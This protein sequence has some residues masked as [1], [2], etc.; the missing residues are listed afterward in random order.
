M[1]RR[2]LRRRA[3]AALCAAAPVAVAAATVTAPGGNVRAFLALSAK[4]TGFPA[5]E[6]D[7]SFAATLDGA[8]R[9]AGHGA[10]LD[11]L[12]AGQRRAGC[13][14]L[15]AAIVDAW[16]SG[17]VPHASG[18]AV[19]TLHRALIWRAAPFARPPSVCAPDWH[20]APGGEAP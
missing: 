8:L 1:A 14:A 19:A 11:A 6:L 4:L 20:R 17:V 2:G 7:S 16:Y 3:F 9:H 5:A 12:A 15:E 18:P 10:R 13:E